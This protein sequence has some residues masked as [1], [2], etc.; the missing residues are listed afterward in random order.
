VGGKLCC[1]IICTNPTNVSSADNGGTNVRLPWTRLR[2]LEPVLLDMEIPNV[3]HRTSKEQVKDEMTCCE[4]RSLLEHKLVD[5][6]KE[7]KASLS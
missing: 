5:R 2:G 4:F 6:L 7:Y 3:V 1:K